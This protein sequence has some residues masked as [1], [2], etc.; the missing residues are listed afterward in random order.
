[1][2]CASDGAL[3]CTVPYLTN[4][5]PYSFTVRAWNATGSSPA[6]TPS[7]A[8]TPK[9]QGDGFTGV[10]PVRVLDSRDG[11]GLAGVWSG[12][13]TRSLSVRGVGGVPVEATAVVLNVT[14]TGGSATS[15]LRLWPSG[16]P[17]PEV[18]NLN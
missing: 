15:N 1:A 8:V 7:H 5:I 18:S 3:A 9:Q 17:Q 11:T 16:E 14:V 12:G 6:S 10:Q 4:G 13:Q 2:T